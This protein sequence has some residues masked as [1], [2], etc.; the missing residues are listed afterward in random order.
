M[1]IDEFRKLFTREK[2]TRD[3]LVML[4]CMGSGIVLFIIMAF[5]AKIPDKGGEIYFF[6]QNLGYFFLSSGV[7]LGYAGIHYGNIVPGGQSVRAMLL[8]TAKKAHIIMG[9][10]LGSILAILIISLIELIP[11]L[12]GYIPY[13]GPV[14]VA[15]LSVPY[16]IINL[17]VI[18]AVV[19][20]WIV[21]P[22]MAAEGTD[23]KKMPLDYVTLVKRRGLV[24][25][26]Y[27]TCILV[28]LGLLFMPLLMAIRYSVGITRA[29]E[30]NIAPVY[31]QIFKSI[32]R[33]SYITDI[34]T[35]IA[36]RTDP[37]ATLQEYGT[38]LFNY[39]DMLGNFLKVLYGIMLGAL[40]AFIAAVFG[41]MMSIAYTWV[42][43]D[44]LK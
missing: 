14:L 36:P 22:P 9:I 7:F 30:W 23:L 11:V 29:V 33:P 12:L 31:P 40:T 42:R 37:I 43:K 8:G 38:S 41:N 6:L 5:F 16:F 21:L 4:T 15:I 1:I 28:V 25:I 35:K 44:L 27:T 2:V 26:V 17:A 39:I 19:L 13:A 32:I 20:V 18:I 24:I 34:I 10:L 3:F